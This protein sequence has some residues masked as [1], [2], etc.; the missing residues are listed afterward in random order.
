MLNSD[1]K[2]ISYFHDEYFPKP[3]N[4]IMESSDDIFALS[5]EAKHFVDQQIL[6]ERDSKKRIKLLAAAMFD[7]SKVSLIYTADANTTASETFNNQLANCLSMTILTYAMAE[8]AGL[9][10][11]FQEVFIPEYWMRSEQYSVLNRHVNVR[12]KPTALAR[13]EIIP[14]ALSYYADTLTVDFVVD[15][16]TKHYK[17]KIIPKESVLAMYFNNKGA[18]EILAK[19][20]N[21]AYWYF[22]T[23]LQH[24]SS[25][26][27]AWGNL[28]V[29]YRL[30]HRLE[31]VEPVYLYAL[32]LDSENYSILEN[33]AVLK[34][35]VNQPEQANAIQRKLQQYRASNPYY[36]FRLAEEQYDNGDWHQAVRYYDRAI[37]LDRN[38]HDFYFGL[39]K[40][41]FRLGNVEKSHKYL[42]KAKMKSFDE[43]LELKYQHK[44]DL[45]GRL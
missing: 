24:D 11:D 30:S 33:L 19:N 42:R 45:L 3:E 40:A 10:A 15:R 18:E 13:G 31:W 26:V 2:P 32:A 5:E 8:Y 25:F 17:T 34:Q 38:V 37:K 16:S 1:G 23:A 7:K 22:K 29:T 20:L 21:K 4:M 36:Y 35:R 43:D 44:L 6:T 12:L 39:A 28:G 41:W 9:S 14:A 27:P